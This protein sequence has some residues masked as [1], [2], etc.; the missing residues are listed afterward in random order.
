MAVILTILLFG[1]V[2]VLHELGHF[3]TAKVNKIKINAFS[4]GMGPKIFSWGKDKTKYFLRALPIGGYVSIDD[5][6]FEKTSIHKRIAV[7]LAGSLV[8][9]VSGFFIISIIVLIQGQF[10]STKVKSATFEQHKIQIGDYIESV[11]NHH[12][13]GANDLIFELSKIDD[14]TPIN[15]TV[16]RNDK[17]VELDDVGY[18]INDGEQTH[19]T[20]GISLDTEQLTFSKFFQTS[21]N[22]S[23]FVTK[24][25]WISICDLFTGKI[26]INNVSGP[27]GFT[28]SVSDAKTH[29]F[30]SVMSLF[31]LLSINIGIFNLLPFPALDGGRFVFL[32]IEL[33]SKKKVKKTIQNYVNAFG[34][35]ILIFLFVVIAIKDIFSFF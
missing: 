26:S 34:I 5:D 15:I 9:I 35:L 8:N 21:F 11:N 13:F 14:N 7:I 6:N 28:K 1:I 31:P 17:I 22:S 32:L 27:I 18:L 10:I 30:L 12:I 16:L 4:I 20:L 29:G 19:R 23:I 24:L 2:V 33:I 25:V 3:L